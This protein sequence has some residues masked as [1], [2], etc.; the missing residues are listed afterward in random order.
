MGV[1]KHNIPNVME[2]RRRH[3]EDVAASGH[4]R[5]EA[6]AGVLAGQ[7]GASLLYGLMFLLVASLVSALV[8]N[9][10]TTALERAHSDQKHQQDNLTL[11]S[12]ANLVR[13]CLE[14]TRF[15]VTTVTDKNT[16]VRVANVELVSGT[17]Q[18]ADVLLDSMKIAS[19][20]NALYAGPT[21]ATGRSF[22]MSV[23]A[24]GANALNGSEVLVDYSIARKLYD[25]EPGED[26]T[27]YRIKAALTLEGSN[28]MLF[29]EGLCR[30]ARAPESTSTATTITEVE[31]VYW[32]TVNVSTQGGVS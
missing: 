21:D 18:F 2:G 17:G 14:N 6:S 3:R 7:R 25:I 30:G 10:S 31:E 32:D 28:E 29:L 15:K 8:L 9:A 16:S 22:K 24:T 12:A 5:R 19:G 13:D 1:L 4:E 26:D 27:S 23:E 11:T 20:E